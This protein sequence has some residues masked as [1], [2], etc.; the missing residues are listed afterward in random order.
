MTDPRQHAARRKLFTRAFSKSFLRQRWELVVLEK[1]RLAVS[2]I[3]DE[4]LREG[5]TDMMKWWMFLATDVSA[6]LM[7]GESF[8]TLEGGKVRS[9][10]TSIFTMRKGIG[11][12]RSRKAGT[13]IFLRV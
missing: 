8:R 7:F 2:R 1:V 5:R 13:I 9:F 4:V 11:L 3:R 12:I 6:H 10:P